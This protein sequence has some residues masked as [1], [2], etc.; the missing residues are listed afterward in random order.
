MPPKFKGVILLSQTNLQYASMALGEFQVPTQPTKSFWNA[1][2]WHFHLPFNL[3]CSAEAFYQ[4]VFTEN[5]FRPCALKGLSNN[6]IMISRTSV[7]KIAIQYSLVC[8]TLD[9]AIASNILLLIGIVITLLACN[10]DI[11]SL[12]LS[13]FKFTKMSIFLIQIY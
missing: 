1:C 2:W 11:E 9:I 8:L 10:V 5:R 12:C 3:V 7:Q 4:H 6:A 13:L